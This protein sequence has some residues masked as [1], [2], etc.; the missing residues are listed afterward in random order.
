M[1]D[2]RMKQDDLDRKM[3]GS[4][5]ENYGQQLPGRNPRDN[6]STGQRDAGRANEANMDDD[7]FKDSSSGNRQSTGKQN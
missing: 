5:D 2:D 6:K 4:E 3:G 7:D 1:A